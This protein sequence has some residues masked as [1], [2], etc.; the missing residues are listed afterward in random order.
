MVTTGKEKTL[1]YFETCLEYLHNDSVVIIADIHWSDE[2]EQ[3]W[4]Q[5]KKHPQVSLSVDLFHL[6]VLFFREELK[7]K[8][9]VSLVR[10]RLKP[11]RLGFF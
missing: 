4:E 7:E 5:L 2:M 1:S 6:G 8:K 3:C 9:D 10:A 11:W